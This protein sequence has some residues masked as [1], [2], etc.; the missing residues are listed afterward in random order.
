M[1]N[2]ISEGNNNMPMGANYFRSN[3][4]QRGTWTTD[5]NGNAIYV[6]PNG[7]RQYGSTAGLE[8]YVTESMFDLVKPTA[9]LE[10]DNIYSNRR[11]LPHQTDSQISE[12]DYNKSQ[13]DMGQRLVGDQEDSLRTGLNKDVLE[14]VTSMMMMPS[15]YDSEV[16]G[17]DLATQRNLMNSSLI[18]EEGSSLQSDYL[19][20]ISNNAYGM[21]M[22][23]MNQRL[24]GG[25]EGMMGSSYDLRQRQNESSSRLL[26]YQEDA[27]KA[28]LQYNTDYS[29]GAASLLPS[30][31]SA[32]KQFI[33]ASR[34]G[35]DPEA[36]AK[37][38]ATDAVSAFKDSDAAY[39]R[40]MARMGIR[41][42]SGAFT[43][44]STQ[45]ALAITQ[46]KNNAR[47]NAENENYRRLGAVAL[48]Q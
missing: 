3:Q 40:N 30:R 31:F 8:N 23:A 38:A 39:Q 43:D 34:N 36:Y 18:G 45:R 25:M 6:A 7:R 20:N 33:D 11:I 19:R 15:I 5:E 16:S 9:D 1:G 41:P 28:N 26:P 2:V 14:N 12:Y 27:T 44:N 47:Q 35:V 10:L 24:M 22:N 13:Y 37:R 46:A 17:Y 48:M 21:S 29:K 4:Q 42:G 32:T